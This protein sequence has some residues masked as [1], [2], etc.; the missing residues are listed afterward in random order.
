[1]QERKTQ[2]YLKKGIPAGNGSEVLEGRNVEK[3]KN[4]RIRKVA[5]EL[6]QLSIRIKTT[7]QRLEGHVTGDMY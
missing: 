6:E 4:L 1:M 3:L 7:S 2:I 5:G